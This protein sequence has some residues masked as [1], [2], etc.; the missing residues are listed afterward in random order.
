MRNL[1]AAVIQSPPGKVVTPE[2]VDRVLD[3]VEHAE[4]VVLPELSTVPY[5]PVERKSRDADDP[6]ALGGA[7][8][9][10]FGAVA[11]SH[12]CHMM[13]GAYLGIDGMSANSAV[14]LDPSG[15]CALGRT[16]RGG[17]ALAFQKVHLCDVE[18]HDGVFLESDYFRAGD[19]YIVWDTP[20]G[21]V[22]VL[23]CYDRHFSEAWTSLRVMGAEIV[24]VCTTSPASTQPT[25]VAEMQ[26]MALQQSVF[27]AVA[28]RVGREVLETSGKETTFLGASCIIDPEGHVLEAAPPHDPVSIVT[29]DLRAERLTEIRN[30]NLFW[31]HRRPATYIAAPP[32]PD[33]AS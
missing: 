2:Y 21:V 20:F 29:A 28:N 13:L 5:F 23:I 33:S 7:L 9:D 1:R 22:G 15:Q 10:S 19:E 14:L 18:S 12:A 11:R 25:F 26:A 30:Q 6:A 32:A 3:Q 8:I 16:S 31:T 24:C 4:L 27:V 17:T